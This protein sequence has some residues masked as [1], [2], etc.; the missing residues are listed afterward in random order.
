MWKFIFFGLIIWLVFYILKNKIG[1]SKAPETDNT[2]NGQD[3]A[4]TQNGNTGEAKDSAEDSIED[5][6]QC[7]A[8]SVHLPRS[9]AFMVGGHFY[10]SQ[11]HI[12]RK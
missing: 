6:V 4:K 8:C 5:M 9:E 12:K 1:Q 11:A 7:E 10:C 3:K 2:I